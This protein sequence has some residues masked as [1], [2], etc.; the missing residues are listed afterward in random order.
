MEK[1]IVNLIEPFKVVCIDASNKP[2]SVDNE[3]WLEEGEECI[4]VGICRDLLTEHRTYI[5]WGKNPNPFDGYRSTRFSRI[6]GLYFP[7]ILSI[8]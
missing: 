6:K 3:Q 5:L 8:N 7:N 1:R 2:N 4:V